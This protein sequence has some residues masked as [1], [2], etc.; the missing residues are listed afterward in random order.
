MTPFLKM[1]GLGN[2]FVVFDSRKSKLSLD[3]HSA[4]AVADR[5]RGIGCDQVIVIEKSA[6]DADAL[7]RIYN[8]DGSEVESC[9]N[10]A[11]CVAQV[12]MDESRRDSVRLDTEGGALV[13]RHMDSMISVDMGP[14]QLGW[15]DIPLSQDCDTNLFTVSIAGEELHGA[16][17]VSMGNPHCVL[18]V[19][20]VQDAAVDTIGP[21]VESA[22]LFPERTNV[23]FVQVL[24]AEK[25]R[26]RVWERGTGMTL[27]CGTGA[28]AAM[29]AAKRRGLCGA[30]AEVLLD[31]GPL[32]IE[33]QDADSHVMMIGP[34]TLVYRGE[35]DLRALA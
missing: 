2:D 18:F 11:R 30:R 13:C 4:R 8:A 17:A 34:A 14:P 23:E 15:R 10:A 27:A 6:N 25:L 33:W 12:L 35:I 20:K 9:G 24:S 19:Q 3:H 7:M 26:V 29:V 5:R 22:P 21:A 16:A 1:H 28:C 31:G 32:T